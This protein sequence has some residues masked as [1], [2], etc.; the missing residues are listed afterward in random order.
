MTDSGGMYHLAASH[1]L[2]QYAPGRPFERA[3]S[4]SGFVLTPLLPK[5]TRDEGGG[6]FP[7]MSSLFVHG[8]LAG[9]PG[10]PR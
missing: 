7:P 1:P 4:R 3:A 8:T 6:T 2:R 10:V 9:V 5:P